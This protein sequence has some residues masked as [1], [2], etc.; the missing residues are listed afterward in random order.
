M[1]VSTRVAV[2]AFVRLLHLCLGAALEHL[3]LR[4]RTCIHV[5]VCV[6]VCVRA[7][8]CLADRVPK[9]P[10]YIFRLYMALGNYRQAARTAV[11]IAK[12]VLSPALATLAS[13][14]PLL[15]LLRPLPPARTL[16]QSL[17][18]PPSPPP[19]LRLARPLRVDC[20]ALRRPSPLEPA[21]GG[22]AVLIRVV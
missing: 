5:W 21:G 22:G 12:Q 17:P 8:A 3:H 14:P 6:Y 16:H 1:C 10:N 18:H 20:G 11:I 4:A 7:R 15:S 9:D 13:P 2:D 19:K